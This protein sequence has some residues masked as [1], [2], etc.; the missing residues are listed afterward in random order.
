MK[1]VL[2]RKHVERSCEQRTVAKLALVLA[3]H[4]AVLVLEVR[5]IQTDV[6]RALRCLVHF[7]LERVNVSVVLLQRRAERILKVVNRDKLREAGQNVLNLQEA[8]A[9]LHHLHGPG[10]R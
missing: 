7:K 2:A 6:R 4:H 8:V 5:Q 3:A 10:A 9:L 1:A